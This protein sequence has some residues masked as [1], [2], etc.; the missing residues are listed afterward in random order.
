[1]PV[2]GQVWPFL[3]Q[4][5]IFSGEGVKLSVPSYQGTNETLFGAKSQFLV[6][7]S[8][9][10]STEHINSIPG[11]TTF[12]FGPPWKK[13]PFPRQF[14][15][16]PKSIFWPKIC[17]FFVFKRHPKSAKRHIFIWER[18]TFLFPQLFPVVARTW[19]ESRSG[20]L[21]WAQKL[22]FQPKNQFF[23]I[24]RQILSMVRL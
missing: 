2:L 12:P 4:K 11:A 15:V 5:F 20:R 17:F 23:A 21:F 3:G 22:W 16:W 1:M 7:E 24:R 8:Q 13:I 14:S 18:G 19:R 6:L 9:Y 10:L